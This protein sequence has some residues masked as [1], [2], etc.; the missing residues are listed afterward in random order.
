MNMNVNASKYALMMK[1]ILNKIKLANVGKI[2]EKDVTVFFEIQ[3]IK[4]G[5]NEG[6]SDK[7]WENT[8]FEI[9]CLPVSVHISLQMT[10]QRC[11]CI[12]WQDECSRLS[13]TQN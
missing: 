6:L 11:A 9:E 7:I 2:D 8:D 13:Q 12:I 10:V 4:L 5:V 3:L 1:F